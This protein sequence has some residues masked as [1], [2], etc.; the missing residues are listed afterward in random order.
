MDGR[1]RVVIAGGSGFIGRHLSL[2]LREG[3]YDVVILSR[4]ASRSGDVQWDGKDLGPW[5]QTFEGAA[6]VINL[7]GKSIAEM[8]PHNKQEIRDSR[9]NST[10]LFGKAIVGCTIPP[11][12]WINANAIGYYGNRG[13][14][15]LTEES[16]PGDDFLATL[17]QQWQEPLERY[18]TPGTRKV[19]FRIGFVLGKEGSGLQPMAMAAKLFVGGTLGSG[20][21]WISWIHI[22]DLVGLFI[23]A[24]ET[25][26]E[27]PVNATAP[28]PVT[29]KDFMMELRKTLGRPWAPPAPEFALRLIGKVMTPDPALALMSQRAMP[30]IA[31]RQGYA[32]KYADL[33]PALRSLL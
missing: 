19:W 10:E 6:A 8:N 22:E 12:V 23:W 3:G 21:Q 33:G 24:I 1:G 31:T 2:V 29:N 5:V 7:S 13:D 32:F 18:E 9:L 28:H 17:G 11:A 14:E 25:A 4:N 27:G 15:V 20:K 16:A 26:A 30:E